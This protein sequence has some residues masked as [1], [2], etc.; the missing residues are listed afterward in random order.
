MIYPLIIFYMPTA[1]KPVV[2]KKETSA[3]AQPDSLMEFEDF[4]A[5]KRPKSRNGRGWMVVLMIIVI[6]IL[7][8]AVYLTRDAGVQRSTANFVAVDLDNG[9]TFYAKIVDEDENTLYL[10]EVYYIQVTQQTIP[11]AEGEEGAEPQTVNVPILIKR[12]QE[13]T[14]PSGYLLVNRDKV[15][16]VEEIGPDS[17]IIREIERL[18][19]QIR[20]GA[21]N[22]NQPTE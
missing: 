16:S 6:A 21:S 18:N 4:V 5:T 12:G 13:I 10:D 19:E 14:R 3:S 11:A 22:T 20:Q 2:R 15:I 17:D 9:Q 8:A 1:K 7:G